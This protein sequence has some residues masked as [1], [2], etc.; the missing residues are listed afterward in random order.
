[1]ANTLAFLPVV[2]SMQAWITVRRY[3]SASFHA[4]YRISYDGDIH[5]DFYNHQDL[6]FSLYKLVTQTLA[7]SIP[8]YSTNY[9]ECATRISKNYLNN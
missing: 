9:L 1:M 7:L 4:L 6:G 8:L 2:S 5:K 3:S